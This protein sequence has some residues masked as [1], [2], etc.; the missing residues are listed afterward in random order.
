VMNNLCIAIPPWAWA[1]V[2]SRLC[3]SNANHLC[4]LRKDCT[5]QLSH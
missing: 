2:L 3:K 5:G 1:L 4:M